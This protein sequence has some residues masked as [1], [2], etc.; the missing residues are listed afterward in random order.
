VFSQNVWD[1]VSLPTR[2]WSAVAIS[3][4]GS[5]LFAGGEGIYISTNAGTIWK[6]TSAPTNIWWTSIASSADGNKL[7]ATGLETNCDLWTRGDS[8]PCKPPTIYVG[9]IYTSADAGATWMRTTAP[10]DVEWSSVASSADGKRLVAVGLNRVVTEGVG[11]RPIIY[12][13]KDCGQ[14]WKQQTNQFYFRVNFDS[15]VSSADGGKL[16]GINVDGKIFTSPDSGETWTLVNQDYPN[17]SLLTYSKCLAC[18]ADGQRLVVGF[19]RVHNGEPSPIFISTNGGGSWFQTEAPSNHWNCLAS[20]ADG[21]RLVAAAHATLSTAS[22]GKIFTST[23]YGATWTENNVISQEWTCI[24]MSADGGKITAAT[25]TSNN[26]TDAGS[27]FIST[28]DPLTPSTV[29]N[30]SDIAGKSLTVSQMFAAPL[31]KAT[32][33]DGKLCLSWTVSSVGVVLEQSQD[34]K[35][36]TEVT[37]A[38]VVNPSNLQNELKILPM[39][40]SGF[41]RLKIP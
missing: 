10:A 27:V 5:K 7:V 11:I 38:P 26:L 31:L 33:T 30:E 22:P 4:D 35:N 19:Q 25:T 40:N 9:P 37:N 28:L 12:T 2:I 32:M 8:D 3:A 14:T 6:V 1:V 36:W 24:A 23:N 29:G 16:V 34:L 39:G 15:V 13:S 20:S 17:G 21:R 18:S 41:F